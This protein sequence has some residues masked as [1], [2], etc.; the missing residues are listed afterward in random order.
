THNESVSATHQIREQ[1]VAVPF[2]VH[3]MDGVAPLKPFRR[4]FHASVPAQKFSVCPLCRLRP[5]HS[6][7][8]STA[9]RT[10]RANIRL[11]VDDSERAPMARRIDQQRY[12]QKEP[13]L[14]SVQIAKFFRRHMSKPACRRSVKYEHTLGR[15]RASRGSLMML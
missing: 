15:H 10:T 2:A 13:G 9:P 6:P 11:G 1:R 14:T 4:L 8:A 12:M 7:L 5:R 3:H